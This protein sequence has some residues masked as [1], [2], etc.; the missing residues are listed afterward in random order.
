MSFETLI[1][2]LENIMRGDDLSG[3]VQYLRQIVWMIFLKIYDAKEEE[4]EYTEYYSSIIPN[5]LKWRNWAEDHQD[6]TALTGDDLIC[7]VNNVL[8]RT[9]KELPIDENT[10]KKQRIVKYIFEDAANYMK[11]GTKLRQMINAF[12]EVDFTDYTEAHEF[13]DMYEGML[14]D[15]QDSKRDGGEFYTP[16]ALTDFIVEIVNPDLGQSIGEKAVA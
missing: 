10:P 9:L 6:G 1:K 16:R 15:L 11:D 13:G 14:K 2:R 3:K 8:F 7:F 12:N 4:W 5:N